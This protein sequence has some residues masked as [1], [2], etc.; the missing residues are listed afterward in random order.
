M[1][2]TD[3]VMREKR[4]IEKKFYE[5]LADNEWILDDPY[6][7]DMVQMPFHELE[8]RVHAL[9]SHSLAEARREERTKIYHDLLNK[10]EFVT[11][12]KDGGHGSAVPMS[13]V[14]DLL[15]GDNPEESYDQPNN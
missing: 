11:Y 12:K 7:P 9:L 4:D 1:K 15:T 13:W 3:S 5:D 2:P 10:Q 6:S 14:L 8:K